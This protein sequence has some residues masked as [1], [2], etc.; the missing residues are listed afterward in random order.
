[1]TERLSTVIHRV[2]V[3]YLFI[4]LFITSHVGCFQFL[5]IV[6]RATMDVG[7]QNNFETLLSV[8]SGV[9]P[10]VELL[11]VMLILCLIL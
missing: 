11:D 1:M 8:L 10:A 5:T 6:N 3:P 9:Y 2:P 7:V 4:Y